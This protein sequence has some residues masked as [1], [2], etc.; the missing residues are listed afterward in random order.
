MDKY[1]LFKIK[2]GKRQV[3][4]D[5][6]TELMTIHKDEASWTLV[7]EDL[8][9]EMCLIFGEKDDS[10]VVYRWRTLTGKEKKPANMNID[11]NKKHFDKF[12]ECLDQIKPAVD[13][14]NID[15]AK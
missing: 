6:C 2:Q 8:V 1:R 7:E 13:G 9:N 14:Y 12:H 11:L 5:W 15:S 4:L 10:Y 3:W